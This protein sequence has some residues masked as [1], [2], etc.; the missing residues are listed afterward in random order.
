MLKDLELEIKT[1]NRLATMYF[2]CEQS[3]FEQFQTG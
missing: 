3:H 2:Q 1:N